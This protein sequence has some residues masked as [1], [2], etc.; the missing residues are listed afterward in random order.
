[1]SL[2]TATE[3]IVTALGTVSGID[4]ISYNSYSPVITENV[5]VLFVPHNARSVHSFTDGQGFR[6]ATVRHTIP[7]EIWVKYVRGQEATQ[8]QTIRTV[9]N[10]L[11]NKLV[12]NEGASTYYIESNAQFEYQIDPELVADETQLP[13]FRATL[14]VP[15]LEFVDNS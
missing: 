13:W 2:Q 4:S 8:M 10:T 9:G 3:N 14:T 5:C 12:A 6:C 7:A 15:I 1:M 11:V